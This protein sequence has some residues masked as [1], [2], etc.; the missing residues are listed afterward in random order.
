MVMIVD[1]GDFYWVR[2]VRT[3]R[4]GVGSAG[5]GNKRSC[6]NPGPTTVSS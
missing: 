5:E 1:E 4:R 2:F 6:I 3:A